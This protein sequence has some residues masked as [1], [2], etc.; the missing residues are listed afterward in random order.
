MTCSFMQWN[1]AWR[2]RKEQR[3]VIWLQGAR[4]NKHKA[5]NTTTYAAGVLPEVVAVV[6]VD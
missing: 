4:K 1:M 6:A 5:K 2:T 3:G